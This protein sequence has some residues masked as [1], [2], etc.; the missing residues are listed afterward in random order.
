MLSIVFTFYQTL[1][2]NHLERAVYSLA[3]QV[4]LGEIADELVFVDNNTVYHPDQIREIVEQHHWPRPS[5]HFQKHGD[6]NRRHS[7]SANYGFRAAANEFVFF[8]RADYILME[9]A[10]KRMSEEAG[11]N[12][13]SFVSGWCYQM[14]YDRQGITT[15]TEPPYE[16]YAWRTNTRYL[17]QYPYA[18]EYP[19][20]Q[21][22][23]GVFV[24]S[25]TA[26][27]L[28]GWFDEAMISFGYQQ[29]TLQRQMRSKG[30]R[31]VAV[32]DFLFCH[33]HH[34]ATRDFAQARREYNNSRRG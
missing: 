28:A 6:N 26:M 2:L 19:E 20:T 31:M 7:W 14:G 18:H 24:T 4:E 1:D 5:Y 11:D 32:Q 33:Q 12:P 27:D 9:D 10:L 3:Q 15:D 29:S 22:D 16:A 30:I 34:E 21:L 23:A 25:K 17:L 8:T 13:K